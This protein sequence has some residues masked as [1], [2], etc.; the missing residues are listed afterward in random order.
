M[1][2]VS[3]VGL[4]GY[5]F[6]F[7]L[8]LIENHVLYQKSLI[9]WP[10]P[11]TLLLWRPSTSPMKI[12]VKSS[13]DTFL[14]L[15]IS[16][17]HCYNISVLCGFK[18]FVSQERETV[19]ITSIWPLCLEPCTQHSQSL[20]FSKFPASDS[21]PQPPSASVPI[22][23]FGEGCGDLDQRQLFSWAPNS[24]CEGVSLGAQH[25][26][27]L[28]RGLVTYLLMIVLYEKQ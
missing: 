15:F 11:N 5:G 6:F 3:L 14:V 17:T 18:R 25:K 9:V 20:N 22:I 24:A 23:P 21:T 28:E 13:W 19:V 12:W 4:N 8:V 27:K 2:A 1:L 10:W 7:F 26:W 16:T